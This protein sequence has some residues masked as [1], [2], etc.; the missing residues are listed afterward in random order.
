V[1]A[2][3]GGEDGGVLVVAGEVFEEGL[4]RKVELADNGDERV[5][6]ALRRIGDVDLQTYF[7]AADLAVFPYKDILNS[8]SALMA[9]T[10]DVPLL[11]PALGSMPELRE[12]VGADWVMTYGGDLSPEVLAAGRSWVAGTARARRAPLESLDWLP[13]ATRTVEFYRE[14]CA[15]KGTPTGPSS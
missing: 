13:L 3:R 9:L 2:F 11:V 4:K 15:K 1:K 14:V 5:V 7:R 12:Q 8:G 6:L 10:F